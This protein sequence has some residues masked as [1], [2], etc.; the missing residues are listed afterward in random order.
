MGS[1]QSETRSVAG[2]KTSIK[3]NMTAMD[4]RQSGRAPYLRTRSRQ[5]PLTGLRP[6]RLIVLADMAPL[7]MA[8]GPAQCPQTMLSPEREDSAIPPRATLKC[9][10]PVPHG[11]RH[12]ENGP[13]IEIFD[14]GAGRAAPKN[15]DGTVIQGDTA[16]DGTAARMQTRIKLPRNGGP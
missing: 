4:N 10:T 15:V 2:R 3:T 14:A 9:R 7:A 12:L 13:R 1:L 16:L 5:Y 8:A 6:H 11:A